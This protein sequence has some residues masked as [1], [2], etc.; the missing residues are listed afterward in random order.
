MDV[1]IHCS[2]FIV[3]LCDIFISDIMIA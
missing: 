1:C 2:E 3:N